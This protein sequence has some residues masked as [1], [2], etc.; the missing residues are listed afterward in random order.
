MHAVMS[1]ALRT[2]WDDRDDPRVRGR[3]S[4]G[5]Q[6]ARLPRFRAAGL[7]PWGRGPRRV[8]GE[9]GRA[10]FRPAREPAG[11]IYRRLHGAEPIVVGGVGRNVPR[12]P[13]EGGGKPPFGSKKVHEFQ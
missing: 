6:R 5:H 10:S 13:H 2:E 1:R 7:T 8:G 3:G 12:S 11:L 9:I 4:G